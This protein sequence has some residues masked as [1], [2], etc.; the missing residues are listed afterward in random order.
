MAFLLRYFIL[1]V[2]TSSSSHRH[3][4]V[5]GEALKRYW[6]EEL[7]INTEIFKYVGYFGGGRE[8]DSRHFATWPCAT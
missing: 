8:F 5:S 6:H 2:M 4:P 1:I 3:R 7:C